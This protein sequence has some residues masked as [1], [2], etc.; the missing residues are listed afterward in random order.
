MR[1]VSLSKSTLLCLAVS[2][3]LTANLYAQALTSLRGTVTDSQGG[4]IPATAVSLISK[5]TGATRKVLADDQGGYQFLQVPPGA[6]TV[7]AEKPGFS[8]NQSNDVRLVVSTPATLD[9]RLEVG[10][11]SETINVTGDAPALN[12]VDATIGNAFNE[13][14]VRQLPLATRNV[15]ELL[16][17]QA[18]V[19]QTGEV[20]GARRDQNNVTLDGVDVNDNQT[21][22]VSSAGPGN[23]SNA[24]GAR[25]AGF[26][27]ALPGPLASV[28]EFRVT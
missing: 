3:L 13:T 19:T 28:A 27:A 15:V 7:K 25:D 18:G 8:I 26:N 23:G 5:D 17:L 1:P 11:T 10:Q 16:S 4:A 6:Y 20:L 12:T 14:Q 9:I 21:S 22:G 2:S 24:G